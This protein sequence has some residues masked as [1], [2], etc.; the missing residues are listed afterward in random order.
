MTLKQSFYH[1]MTSD[2]KGS[3]SIAGFQVHY[4]YK[5]RNSV[6]KFFILL[7]VLT[8]P[9]AVISLFFSMTS[10]NKVLAHLTQAPTEKTVY[11][12]CTDS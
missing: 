2:F 6:L 7:N 9:T 12:S 5:S 10:Q 8:E 4:I 1:K 11:V 3:V